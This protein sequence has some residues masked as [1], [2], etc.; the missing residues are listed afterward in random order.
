MFHNI[1]DT[2]EEDTILRSHEILV[3][4]IAS[5]T[6]RTAG[7]WSAVALE[8]MDPVKDDPRPVEIYAETATQFLVCRDQKSVTRRYFDPDTGTPY[9]TERVQPVFALISK[10]DYWAGV[11]NYRDIYFNG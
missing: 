4:D 10:E 11:P 7:T 1:I 9:E 2:R 3:Y 8:Y 5:E 6:P